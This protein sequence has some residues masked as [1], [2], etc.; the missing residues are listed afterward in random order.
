M[1]WGASGPERHNELLAESGRR[2]ASDYIKAFLRGS[3]KRLPEE[4]VE[5]I[6]AYISYIYI[7]YTVLTSSKLLLSVR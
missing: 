4:A 3:F 1:Q 5:Y 6:F 2:L 7:L